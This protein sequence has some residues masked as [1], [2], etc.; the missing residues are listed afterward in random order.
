MIDKLNQREEQIHNSL[1][2]LNNEKA[3]ANNV[4]ASVQHALIVTDLNGIIILANNR[5][6][7]VFGLTPNQLLQ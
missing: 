3:F 7:K 6:S 5:C 1:T 4:I 2:Q